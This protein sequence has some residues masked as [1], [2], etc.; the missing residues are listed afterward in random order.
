MLVKIIRWGGQDIEAGTD[1]RW[2]GTLAY[3]PEGRYWPGFLSFE[4]FENWPEAYDT[5]HAEV[6]N[7][8]QWEAISFDD[9]P[10]SIRTLTQGDY[11]LKEHIDWMLED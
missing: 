1:P 3:D 2:Y 6:P 10:E 9:L 4:D 7:N 11:T 8:T 5:Y